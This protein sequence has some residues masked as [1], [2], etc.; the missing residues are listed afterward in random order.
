MDEKTPKLPILTN[1][2]MD[3]IKNHYFRNAIQI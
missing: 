1:V 3:A 2:L